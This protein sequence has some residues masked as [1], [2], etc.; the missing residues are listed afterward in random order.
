MIAA[1]TGALCDSLR[2]NDLIKFKQQQDFDY[3]K[4]PFVLLGILTGFISIYYTQ[5]LEEL[6]IFFRD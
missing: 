4:I 5:I 6:N 2:R 1:A 3:H